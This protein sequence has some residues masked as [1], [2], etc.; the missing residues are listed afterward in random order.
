MI[1]CVKPPNFRT[2]PS[3][4]A[5]NSSNNQ[6]RKTSYCPPP[7][8]GFLK[9]CHNP[10]DIPTQTFATEITESKTTN[11]IIESKKSKALDSDNVWSRYCFAFKAKDTQLR[12]NS[13]SGGIF[14]LLAQSVLAEGGVVFGVGYDEDLR[15]VHKAVEGH[16]AFSE[17]SGNPHSGFR[18]FMSNKLPQSSLDNPLFS[19]K[20]LEYPSDS[21]ES[22]ANTESFGD[23]ES[24]HTDSKN[25]TESTIATESQPPTYDVIKQKT[26][27][28]DS[29]DSLRRSKYVQSD[30]GD[31]FRE[32]K[33]LLKQ[34]RK[35]LFSG[36]Q[37]E[38]QGLLA[39]LKKPYDNLLT[40][41]VICNSVP[42]PKVW[43]IYKQ[44]LLKEEHRSSCD[45]IIDFN[46]RGK[47]YGWD[48]GAFILKTDLRTKIIPHSESTF[49]RGFLD[50]LIT[51]PSCENCYAKDGR[52]GADI[53][54]GDFWG[55]GRAHPEFSDNIGVSCVIAH[56]AKALGALEAIKE[57]GEWEL[58]SYES[59]VAGNR[60]LIHS[61]FANS[62]RKQALSE[63]LNTYATKGARKSMQALEQYLRPKAKN[64][65][66][67]KIKKHL[68]NKKPPKR[69]R[70]AKIGIV[71]YVH[72]HDNYGQILQNY[73]LCQYLSQTY[74]KADI[75]TFADVRWLLYTP[76]K[77]FYKVLERNINA[78]FGKRKGVPSRL[79]A[80][81]RF[82]EFR[83]QHIKMS[84]PRFCTISNKSLAQDVFIVGSDQV[85]NDWGM[86]NFKKIKKTAFFA[87][88]LGFV[89]RTKRVFRNAKKVAYAPSIGSVDIPNGLKEIFKQYL[90]SFDAL[91]VREEC[92]VATLKKLGLESICVP[93][94]T[95]LLSREDYMRILKP[96]PHKN[97]A[98]V[99]MIGSE[100][101][102]EKD[103]LLDFV[104][105]THKILYANANVKN[106][107]S[108]D[109]HTDFYPT[110]QEWLGAIADSEV[111]IT[112]SF[113]GCIFAIIMNTSFFA[114]KLGGSSEATNT[115]FESLLEIFGLQDRLCS[116]LEEFKAKYS[117]NTPIDWQVINTRLRLWSQVGKDYLAK[118][119][120]AYVV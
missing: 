79:D 5:L 26:S 80:K 68:R 12:L 108:Y 48:K 33:A 9:F 2:I 21:L 81:R 22:R 18:S 119:V 47:D 60:A 66:F 87:Y 23:L 13:S 36:V 24:S 111:L 67:K 78:F 38:I 75:K 53:T 77:R 41:E 84:L 29:L 56:N 114:L 35:V 96:L 31:S 64:K 95:M 103:M 90:S 112:N 69:V 97:E 70:V 14:S 85:W 82:A 89:D 30:K 39:Y 11:D 16:S 91:S 98:F 61:G 110:P 19:S 4:L 51:R 99:Y 8:N 117:T 120:G 63:I 6:H 58:S 49:M 88:L 74:P 104:A 106:P 93:D 27:Q 28:V 40:C 54:L 118:N 44:S 109:T 50:H 37:C 43:E 101:M 115:R 32:A 113:H 76:L 15:V 7:L 105:T 55:V 3:S 34:G 100:T 65:T 86:R 10:H 71:T 62:N 42:S 1:P 52:S 59:I 17:K 46:F 94:P 72:S 73:A 20:I 92:N 102:I 116:N 45:K 107:C 57:Y 25:N 83:S